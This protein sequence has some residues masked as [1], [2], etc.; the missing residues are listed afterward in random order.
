MVSP[1]IA[2]CLVNLA[3]DPPPG[4]AVRA[5]L[6]DF[7][8]LTATLTV[9]RTS[10][11]GVATVEDAELLLA[12]RPDGSRV[13][14]M[15]LTRRT[16]AA[17]TTLTLWAGRVYETDPAAKQVTEYA[18]ADGDPLRMA[19]EYHNP[20]LRLITADRGGPRVAVEQTRADEHY[21]YYRMT[22]ATGPVSVSPDGTVLIGAGGSRNVV[23]LAV[24]RKPG[25]P[26]P[27]QFPRTVRV[28]WDEGWRTT[29]DVQAV[30]VNPPGAPTAAA[31]AD[32][33]V[34][35]DGWRFSSMA[36]AWEESDRLFKE[37]RRDKK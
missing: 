10:R 36:K 12:R 33:T 21:R 11:A 35:P 17:R 23:D 15:T 34:L 3:A 22:A 18:P 19:A 4:L 37:A 24:V 7:D 2:A 28:Q 9:T 5:A 29:W 14:R 25:F 31:I 6:V 26:I 16:T 27:Q 8:T 30:A 32:P 20:A 13:G 1:L